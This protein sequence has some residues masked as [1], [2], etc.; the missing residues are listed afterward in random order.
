MENLISFCFVG[1]D[2]GVESLGKYYL[3][4]LIDG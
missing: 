4:R 1:G 3:F 2:K